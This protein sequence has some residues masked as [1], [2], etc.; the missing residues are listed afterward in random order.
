MREILTQKE[1]DTIHDETLEPRAK[2]KLLGFP[3]YSLSELRQVPVGFNIAETIAQSYSR[4]RRFITR[5]EL[6]AGEWG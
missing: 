6:M 1:Y 2:M 3:E 4:P 5:D